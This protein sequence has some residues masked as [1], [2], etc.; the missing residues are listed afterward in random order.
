[1]RSFFAGLFLLP[2]VASCGGATAGSNGAS[3]AACTVPALPGTI[4]HVELADAGGGMMSGSSSGMGN[5]SAASSMPMELLMDKTS[6]DGGQPVSFI[7]V[8]HGSLLHEMVILQLPAGTLAGSVA[9]GADRKA[10][11][12]ASR[13]EASKA[14][15]SGPGA[16]L[17]S[18]ATGWVTVALQPGA[19]AVI[20]NEPGH[21]T[22]GMRAQFVVR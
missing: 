1:M 14:C 12:G 16:G 6:V 8:N 15:N 13:G 18:G 3:I 20:C 4:V 11:E 10:D 5:H 2:L 21:Y 22:S 17:I 9:V 7:A 19:Y